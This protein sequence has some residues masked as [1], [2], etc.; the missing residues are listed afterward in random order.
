MGKKTPHKAVMQ[1]KAVE[2]LKAHYKEFI[3]FKLP[4]LIRK[5]QLFKRGGLLLFRAS[6]F[7]DTLDYTDTLNIFF[8]GHCGDAVNFSIFNAL[9]FIPLAE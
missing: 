8:C 5:Y 4:H 1:G 9:F 7:T 6:G 2:L 3:I